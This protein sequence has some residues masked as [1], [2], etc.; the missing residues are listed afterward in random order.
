VSNV[1]GLGLTAEVGKSV[2]D[3]A[4]GKAIA[5]QVTFPESE[6][7]VAMGKLTISF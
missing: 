2:A 1:N 6:A 5:I 7:D 4:G 3:T